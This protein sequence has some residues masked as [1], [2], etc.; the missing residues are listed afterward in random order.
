MNHAHLLLITAL[1]SAGSINATSYPAWA[2]PC[3]SHLHPQSPDSQVIRATAKTV[4]GPFEKQE[5]VL[6]PFH[7]NPTLT[8]ASDGTWLLYVIG[9]EIPPESVQNCRTT[10]SDIGRVHI[11]PPDKMESNITLFASQSVLGP[12]TRVGVVLAG[13]DSNRL[14]WDGD[15]TNP[16]AYALPDGSVHLMYRGCKWKKTGFGCSKE[17]IALAIAPHWNCSAEVEGACRY[18]RQNIHEALWQSTGED[19][20]LFRDRRGAWHTLFHDLGRNGGFGCNKKSWKGC[21][22]GGHAF[23]RDGLTWTLSSTRPYTTSVTWEDGFSEVLNRRE[24][25]Q[26]VMATDGVTPIAL[27]NGVQKGDVPPICSHGGPVASNQCQ[28]FTM[29]VELE[30]HNMAVGVEL[31][32][33]GGTQIPV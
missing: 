20:F 21:D 2:S 13:E 26:I 27:I 1:G 31:T 11:P 18:E 9:Q 28:S 8:R 14:I 17:K 19:P 29:A 30:G 23:S 6:K 32:A 10:E 22:V 24:R 15:R 16:S 25:P 33:A 4:W 12:W 3:Y 5:V 7:H